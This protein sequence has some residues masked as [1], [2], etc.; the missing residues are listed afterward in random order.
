[1][2][3]VILNLSK[4]HILCCQAPETLLLLAQKRRVQ[5]ILLFFTKY[6]NCQMLFSFYFSW[7]RI[8]AIL[9][10]VCYLLQTRACGITRSASAR[11]RE[12]EGSRYPT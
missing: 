1:M 10:V 11:H 6:L 12:V 3:N 7:A 9:Q 2:I 5:K 8:Y 4:L